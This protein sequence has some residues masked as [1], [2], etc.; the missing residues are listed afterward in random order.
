MRI[1]SGSILS[2]TEA[3]QNF[4]RVMRVVEQNG[5]AVLFKRNRPKYIMLDINDPE[6]L[7]EMIVRLQAL[8]AERK[9]GAE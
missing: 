5:L 7:D 4:S 8:A 2:V 1:D 6:K 9:E 3:N